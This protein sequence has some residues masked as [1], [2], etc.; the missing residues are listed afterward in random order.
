MIS[1]FFIPMLL[2]NLGLISNAV[3]LILLYLISGFG[4]AGIGMCVMHDA[5][6]GSYSSN[7]SVNKYL[8]YT[9]NL[10]GANS[11]VWKIQHNVLHHTYTNIDKADDDIN[12]PPILRF[13]PHAKWHWFHRFQHLYVWLFYGLSTLSWVTAKDFVRITRYRRLGFLKGKHEFR[14]ELVKMIFWKLAYYCFTLVIPILVLP[15]SWWVVLIAFILMHFTAGLSMSLVFQ[16][17]HV[18]PDMEFPLPDNN[19]VISMDWTV[20]QMLTTTNYAPSSRAFSWLIGGLN[21]QIEH[22]LLPNVC[23]VHYKKLSPIV[24]QTAREYGI[25]YNSKKTFVAAIQD[26]A[27]ML[28]QLGRRA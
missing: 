10:V 23:H 9:M 26:H 25:P 1:L 8:G 12:P 6:H 13:S 11:A 28:Y 15:V 24:L 20:H 14:N 19:G 27:K 18:M 22:H 16:T 7:K 17:A 21:F 3:V 4:M 5:I 2:I